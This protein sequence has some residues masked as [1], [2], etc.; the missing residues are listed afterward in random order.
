MKCVSLERRGCECN[1][2]AFSA[3]ARDIEP[4]DL[5]ALKALRTELAICEE[6][7]AHVP[8]F[9]CACRALELC[10]ALVETP[11]V[12]YGPTTP[13]GRVAFVNWLI[14][15]FGDDDQEPIT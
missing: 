15:P 12:G 6:C 8:G 4:G 5:D 7:G 13:A 14:D 10:R 2:C 3:R 1:A 11:P 9:V